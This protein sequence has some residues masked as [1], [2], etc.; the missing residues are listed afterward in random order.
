[1]SSLKPNTKEGKTKTKQNVKTWDQDQGGKTK[2][3]NVKTED[4][5]QVEEDQD[6]KNVKPRGQHDDQG[7]KDQ[8]HV[9]T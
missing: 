7:W 8:D 6:Y 3:T 9:K 2:T 4:Q 5:D 1:M